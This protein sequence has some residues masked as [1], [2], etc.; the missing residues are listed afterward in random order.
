MTPLEGKQYSKHT[1]EDEF[2]SL[3]KKNTLCVFLTP[4]GRNF[5]WEVIEIL[6]W[7]CKIV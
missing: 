2:I 1:Y 7:G 4:S 6:H 5:T 3:L